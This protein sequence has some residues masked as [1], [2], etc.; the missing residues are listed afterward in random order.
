MAADNI[1]LEI[2]TPTG[3][4]FSDMV[5]YLYVPAQI[6]PTG[7]L[8]GHAALV[9][10]LIPGLLTYQKDGQE[11]TL[12]VGAGFLEVIDNKAEVLVD[13]AERVDDIDVDRAKEARERALQRLL[14][15][16]PDV[17]IIRA[18]AALARA[19][20]RLMAKGII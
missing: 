16:T 10:A 14:E 13:A 1:L 3:P 9:T 5:E 15:P 12:V 7:V 19:N 11:Q 8:A 18:E 17:D 4:V 6:G 20:A 2:V